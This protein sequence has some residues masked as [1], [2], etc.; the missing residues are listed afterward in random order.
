MKK[1]V[2]ADISMQKNLKSVCYKGTGNSYC[3]YAGNVVYP[4]NAV[5]AEKLK[6]DDI[7]KVVLLKTNG[8]KSRVEQ[9]TNIFKN[10]LDEINRN[11]NAKIEYVEL[12]SEYSEEKEN[13]E[14][15]IMAILGQ[16][17]RKAELYGDIT[18]G[19]RTV[20]MIMLCAFAFAEKFYEADIRNIVYGKV[21]FGND[22]KLEN[23]ELYDLTSL[24][25]LNSL[26]YNMQANSAEKAL[27][28]LEA[29]FA[30]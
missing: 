19:P 16:I 20:P 24:Y 12:Q 6:K 27:K 8:D 22:G 3:G 9:N 15:R 21:E 26:T 30:L 2:F 10:E 11:I 1:I 25:Y 23:P 4:I 17:E 28:S 14:K 13:H 18:F 5:L 7:V 29:F